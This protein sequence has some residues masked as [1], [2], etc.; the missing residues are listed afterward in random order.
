MPSSN[1]TLKVLVNMRC[2]LFSLG[3]PGLFG[4][5]F[6]LYMA[7]LTDTRGERLYTVQVNSSHTSII[8][9]L[10]ISKSSIGPTKNL[11]RHYNRVVVCLVGRL[12][13]C[14]QRWL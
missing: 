8:A 2:L 7:G 4:R 13:G 3:I 5:H 11:E 9:D 6:L 10:Q 1:C 12:V 14:S